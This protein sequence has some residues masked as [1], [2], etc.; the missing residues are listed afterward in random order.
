MKPR[1]IYLG[2]DFSGF[3]LDGLDSR[4]IQLLFARARPLAAHTAAAT[5]LT[6]FINVS[7]QPK[8]RKGLTPF[9]YR[10]GHALPRLLFSGFPMSAMSRDYGDVGDSSPPL[11]RARS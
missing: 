10:K 5:S 3:S 11:I 2:G 7:G 6:S 9:S 4:S 8:S 1:G